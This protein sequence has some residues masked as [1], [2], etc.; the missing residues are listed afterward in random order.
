[1]IP[2]SLEGQAMTSHNTFGSARE[3]VEEFY[4]WYAARAQS[5]GRTS[6]VALKLKSSNF[7]PQL[8]K[9]LK[10]DSAA[11]DNC[12]EIVGLD[13][14]PILNTQDPWEHYEVGRITQKGQYYKAEIYGV[15]SGKRN[16]KPDVVAEFLNKDGRWFFVNFYYP[17][18]GTNLMTILRSPR[19]PCSMPRVPTKK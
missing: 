6:D 14:D 16:E 17:S 10:E 1:M 8:A 15:Q 12:A 18:E 4:K 9:L 13:F 3:F 5:K 2:C 19:P 7:S 11:Q